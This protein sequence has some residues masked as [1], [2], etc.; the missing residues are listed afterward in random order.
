MPSF[1][2]EAPEHPWVDQ[3]LTATDDSRGL[4]FRLVDS[5]AMLV[6][7]VDNYSLWYL[8]RGECDDDF[9]VYLPPNIGSWVFAIQINQ[10]PLVQP[11]T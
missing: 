11:S 4:L 1:Q 6:R 5:T 9:T 10:I 7:L 2:T 8:I 3:I